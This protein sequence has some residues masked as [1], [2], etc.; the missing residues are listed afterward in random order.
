MQRNVPNPSTGP[1]LGLQNTKTT[2]DGDRG[3]KGAKTPKW[4]I[5][6]LCAASQRCRMLWGNSS[7]D[8]R[9]GLSTCFVSERIFSCPVIFLGHPGSVPQPRR[10]PPA[11]GTRIA[12]TAPRPP[13]RWGSP[14]LGPTHGCRLL[15][16]SRP[17]CR[18]TA[19][20]PPQGGLRRVLAASGRADRRVPASSQATSPPPSCSFAAL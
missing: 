10:L 17:P 4:G 14:R 19:A 13:P 6:E 3:T 15:T 9:V 11:P 8:S 18:D 16:P 2:W 1:Y 7:L 12:L 5:P 20:P